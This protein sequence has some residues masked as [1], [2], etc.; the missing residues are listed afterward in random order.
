[1]AYSRLL[2]LLKGGVIGKV[3]SVD[4]TCTS[5][6]ELMMKKGRNLTDTWNS[7][8]SWGPTALL[9]IL[10]I[11]GTEYNQMHIYSHMNESEDN[12]DLFTKISF[13]YP[14]A[15]ASIKVGMGVKSEGELI[16][17]GTEG[18]IY[19]PAPWW[20][21][22]YFEVRFENAENN[23]RYFYQYSLLRSISYLRRQLRK[24]PDKSQNRI[25]ISLCCIHS[26]AQC[27]NVS[28]ILFNLSTRYIKSTIVVD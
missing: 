25:N 26:L 17:S 24:N 3:V 16:I 8:C 14:H 23:K 1:M 27:C 2:L 21:T 20:K 7:I 10:Q 22:D 4:A 9:P 11:L 15:V 18:Y 6:S 28:L 12:F 13:S 19:V 5:M